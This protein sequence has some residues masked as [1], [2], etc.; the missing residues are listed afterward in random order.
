MDEI[1][2]CK[3]GDVSHQLVVSRDNPYNEDGEAFVYVKLNPLPF[4]KR[5]V[6]G[7]KYI[8][9]YKCRFGDFDEVI[10]GRE[11]VPRLKALVE[12]LEG[13]KSNKGE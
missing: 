1:L 6:H 3:C 4:W 8:F 12:S 11:H 5:V 7:V 10:L 2:V 13:T 9:G